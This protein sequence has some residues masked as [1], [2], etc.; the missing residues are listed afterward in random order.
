M[1]TLS[2]F[3]SAFFASFLLSLADLIR[4]SMPFNKVTRNKEKLKNRIRDEF[5]EHT[6][7]I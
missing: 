1:C 6:S 4:I 5:T 7:S 3:L 2:I